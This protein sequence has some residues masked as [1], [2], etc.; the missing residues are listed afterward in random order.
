MN[1]D[2]FDVLLVEDSP[3]DAELTI[4]ELKRHRLANKL[5]LVKDG[6]EAL[7]FLYSERKMEDGRT[8]RSLPKIILL[9]IHMPKVDGMEVLRKVRED[10]KMRN[11]PVVI[12]TVSNEH[13]DIQK[14]F[15]LGAK[16]YIVKPLSFEKFS[17]AIRGL[18]FSWV[19]LDQQS[20]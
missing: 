10:G 8:S 11:I 7:E 18:G 16:S 3:E 15:D 20:G 13:P 2:S 6:E 1:F 9:D 5:I 4:W 12:L 14:C 19:L 17:E